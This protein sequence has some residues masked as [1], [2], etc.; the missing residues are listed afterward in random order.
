MNIYEVYPLIRATFIIFFIG[1]LYYRKFFQLGIIYIPYLYF[2]FF[3]ELEQTNQGKE[4]LDYFLFCFIICYIVLL[5]ISKVLKKYT[6]NKILINLNLI[7]IIL[8]TSF[9]SIVSGVFLFFYCG[10]ILLEREAK[11]LITKNLIEKYGE[12]FEVEQIGKVS[13]IEEEYFEYKIV[14]KSYKEDI[15]FEDRYYNNNIARV[16][17]EVS[18][19]GEVLDGSWDSY[20]LV[21]LKESANKFYGEKLK[22]IFG[23]KV[24]P[25]L[26]VKGDYSVEKKD[27]LSSVKLTR[28][29]GEEIEI[30]G[31]VYIFGRIEGIYD[32]EVYREKIFEFIKFMK[33]SGT[34]EY[35]N[36]EFVISDERIFSDEFYENKTLQ[37]QLRKYGN[38]LNSIEKRNFLRRLDKSYEKTS[39]YNIL[40]RIEK[41]NR[42]KINDEIYNLYW[43]VANVSSPKYVKSRGG[44]DEFIKEYDDMS[45]VRFLLAE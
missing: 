11:Q 19:W 1:L 14:P 45:D 34:F 40:K 29:N 7:P 27:F 41:L 10:D 15:K 16:Y 36:I 26:E 20:G 24:L 43:L 35:V 9:L 21:M 17:T 42:G 8:W 25:V 44:R 28:E 13:K 12:E 18:F 5:L 37:N 31:S 23:E 6:T 30:G 32:S 3:G 4:L 38:V 2:I 33:E 22:E 39:K